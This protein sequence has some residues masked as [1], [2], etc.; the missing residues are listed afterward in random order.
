MKKLNYILYMF[1]AMSLLWV[2]CDDDDPVKEEEEEKVVDYGDVDALF[3]ARL[4]TGEL[5]TEVDMGET[6]NLSDISAGRPDKRVWTVTSADGSVNLTMDDA[7]VQTFYFPVGNMTY[8]VKLA[9]ERTSDGQTDELIV[10]DYILVNHVDVTADFTASAGNDDEGAGDFAVGRGISVIFLNKS[11]GV[12]DQYAWEFE[13]GTPITS[14][15]NH[16]EVMF[17]KDGLFEVKLTA[18]RSS[19]G[20]TSE[21]IK[22]VRVIQKYMEVE[23]A[24]VDN[25]TVTVTYDQPVMEDPSVAKD[26]ISVEILTAAGTS[27]N[28]GIESIASDGNVLTITLDKDTYHDDAVRLHYNYETGHLVSTDPAYIAR[29]LN[30]YGMLVKGNVLNS[31]TYDSSF[32]TLTDSNLKNTGWVAA[33]GGFNR[34]INDEVALAGSKSMYVEIG[35]NAGNTGM[36]FYQNKVFTGI[37]E[38]QNY[39]FGYWAYVTEIENTMTST[40][41]WLNNNDWSGSRKIGSITDDIAVGEWRFIIGDAPISA[42]PANASGE[43]RLLVRLQGPGGVCKF[44]MDNMVLFPESSFRKRP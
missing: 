14:D 44:Y 10:E 11:K 38:T 18:T 30:G 17:N 40:L 41:W 15:E 2:S 7:K 27:I 13:N 20:S 35:V 33:H 39:Y 28:A 26:D 4:I 3:E 22:M 9:V 5:I 34:T 23:E 29:S 31:G 8:D 12:A 42:R 16:Q 21:V 19:D 24:W 36:D 6:L 25:R 32:E 43:Q 37:D 1:F